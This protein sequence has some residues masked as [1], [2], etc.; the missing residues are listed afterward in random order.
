MSH[1]ENTVLDVV[2]YYLGDDRIGNPE[3]MADNWV[4]TAFHDAWLT[5][6]KAAPR[7]CQGFIVRGSAVESIDS[8]TGGAEQAYRQLQ[9]HHAHA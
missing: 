7:G 5:R 3:H 9:A 6:P 4:V 8:C 1:I 2:R